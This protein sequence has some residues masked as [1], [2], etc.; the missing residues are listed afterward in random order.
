M[1]TISN[2]SN[3]VQNFPSRVRLNTET[4]APPSVPPGEPILYIWG[5]NKDRTI[6]IRKFLLLTDVTEQELK[7][8]RDS[9]QNGPNVFAVV[10]PRI[11]AGFGEAQ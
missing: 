2:I 11:F 3:V 7:N 8:F 10:T 5:L 1:W 9:T 6:R 4:Q